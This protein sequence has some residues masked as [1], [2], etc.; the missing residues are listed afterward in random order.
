MADE[1]S[2]GIEKAKIDK[3]ME[4]ILPVPKFLPPQTAP[5]SS[6]SSGSQAG[7]G[8]SGNRRISYRDGYRAGNMTAHRQ[9]RT[10]LRAVQRSLT[11]EG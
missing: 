1:L 3:W 2:W 9:W 5:P 4:N 7:R 8:R 11:P 6:P 10:L